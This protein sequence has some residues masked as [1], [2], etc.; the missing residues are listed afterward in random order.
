MLSEERRPLIATKNLLRRRLKAFCV[1]SKFRRAN[2]ME[3]F[4][5]GVEVILKINVE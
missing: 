3:I 1:K 5:H 2:L 4:I